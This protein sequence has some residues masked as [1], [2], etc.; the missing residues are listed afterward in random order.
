MQMLWNVMPAEHSWKLSR[1]LRV[2][3]MDLHAWASRIASTFFTG[4]G[5]KDLAQYRNW[6]CKNRNFVTT[7]K[8]ERKKT[9]PDELASFSLRSSK[10]KDTTSHHMQMKRNRHPH[11]ENK[12]SHALESSMVTPIH[13]TCQCPTSSI[14]QEAVL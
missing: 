10:I 2:D 12:C 6:E 11:L 9:T 4:T 7:Y 3:V 5:Q 14:S 1:T 13:K 8:L